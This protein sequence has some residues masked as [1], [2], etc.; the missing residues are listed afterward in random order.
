MSLAAFLKHIY[1]LNTV[2]H[3]AYVLHEGFHGP[4][5]CDIDFLKNPKFFLYFF[6]NG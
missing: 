1:Y 5:T 4:N 2:T 6:L 3:I